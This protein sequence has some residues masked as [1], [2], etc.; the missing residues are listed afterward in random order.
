MSKTDNDRQAVYSYLMNCRSQV[1]M[2]TFLVTPSG[3]VDHN[4]V[5][6]HD[7]PPRV[8][9]EI[10]GNFVMVGLIEGKGLTIPLNKEA[11]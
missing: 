9:A 1:K 6:V 3:V 4:Y 10:V 11:P 5:V 2:S 8:V 7:A